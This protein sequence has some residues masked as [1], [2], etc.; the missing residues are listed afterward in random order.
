MSTRTAL[1]KAIEIIGLTAM[2]N[3]L[4]IKYQSI[5]GW[6]DRNRMPD[7]E[8]SCRTQYA[9]KIQAMTD[10][11]VTVEQLLGHRPACLDIN[12]AS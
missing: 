11:K 10:D 8:F 2:A 5:R 6:Q 7:T 3:E 12:K 9:V 4:D 1:A